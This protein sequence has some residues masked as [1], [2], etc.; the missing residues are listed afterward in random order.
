VNNHGASGRSPS[1]QTPNEP[2]P[3]MLQPRATYAWPG[4][5]LRERVKGLTAPFMLQ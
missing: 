4:K 3:L 1:L 2:Q 5:G